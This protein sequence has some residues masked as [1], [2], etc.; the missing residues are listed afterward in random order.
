MTNA[1]RGNE[2]K[3]ILVSLRQPRKTRGYHAQP[4][5]G[6]AAADRLL[7][8]DEPERIHV[9]LR[10]VATTDR[11]LSMSIRGPGLIDARG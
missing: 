9:A 10:L 8:I 2:I 5:E 6:R 11:S 7:D 4:R 3:F 1:E